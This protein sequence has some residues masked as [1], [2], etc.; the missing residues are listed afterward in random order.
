MLTFIYLSH[1]P[2]LNSKRITGDHAEIWFFRKLNDE[3]AEAKCST[4]GDYLVN[5][6]PEYEKYILIVKPKS[7]IHLHI[8]IQETDVSCMPL[9]CAFL[10]FAHAYSIF[11]FNCP[12]CREG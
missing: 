9:S 10:F 6:N 7:G 8:S 12:V 11:N 3:E 1:F 4:A 5:Y 2:Q